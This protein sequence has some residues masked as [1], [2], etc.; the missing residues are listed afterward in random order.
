MQPVAMT[1]AIVVL[2]GMAAVSAIAGCRPDVCCL[3]GLAGAAAAYVIASWAWQTILKIMYDAI[4]NS[5]NQQA[6]H[7]GT[8]NN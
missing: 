1:A 6:E 5:Q 2:I 7:D 3:R 8:N 4:N